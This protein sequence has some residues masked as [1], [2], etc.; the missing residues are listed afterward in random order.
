MISIINI[1]YKYLALS[2]VSIYLY[3]KC[4]DKIFINYWYKSSFFIWI[5]LTNLYFFRL[6]RNDF[7]K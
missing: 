1:L 5:S 3:S 2:S 6:L 7:K 4:F